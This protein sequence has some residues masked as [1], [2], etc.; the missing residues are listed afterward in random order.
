MEGMGASMGGSTGTSAGTCAGLLM[1][2]S[3]LGKCASGDLA[4]MVMKRLLLGEHMNKKFE[5]GRAHV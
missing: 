3:H 5:I 4:C 2:L 1:G